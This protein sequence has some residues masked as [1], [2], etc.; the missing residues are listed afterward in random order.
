MTRC[1]SH[2]VLLS[3]CK[4]PA[5]RER[6]LSRKEKETKKDRGESLGGGEQH[7]LRRMCEICLRWGLLSSERDEAA[8]F[9]HHN[10][11]LSQPSQD[12]TFLIP[13]D[14]YCFAPPV[15]SRDRQICI[16]L[17]R[18]VVFRVVERFTQ[19]QG[20]KVGRRVGRRERQCIEC[21]ESDIFTEECWCRFFAD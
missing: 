2:L 16:W 17:Q 7:I 21:H 11:N 4:R 13:R 10:F 14:R 20:S 18:Y 8:F 6:S 5:M 9:W 15:A 3:S 12:E 1:Q 19:Q